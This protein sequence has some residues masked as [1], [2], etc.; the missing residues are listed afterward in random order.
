MLKCSAPHQYE[1]YS[2]YSM[3]DAAFP[4]LDEAIAQAEAVCLDRFT[5]YVGSDY[6]TSALGLDYLYPTAESWDEG[7]RIILCLLYDWNGDLLN[8]SMEGSGI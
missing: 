7:D 6:A 5:A 8:G 4:G 2:E 3:T 1:A